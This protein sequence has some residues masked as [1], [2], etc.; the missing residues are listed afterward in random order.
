MILDLLG[1]TMLI[2]NVHPPYGMTFVQ[3]YV[4]NIYFFILHWYKTLLN[5]MVILVD[6]TNCCMNGFFVA[7]LKIWKYPCIQKNIPFTHF[8]VLV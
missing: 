1:L 8:K 2:L 3:L 6:G 7:S 5:G 4:W